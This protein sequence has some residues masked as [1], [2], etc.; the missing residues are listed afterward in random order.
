MAK[1]SK[2]GLVD[3]TLR[4]YGALTHKAL[5]AYLARGEPRRYLYDLVADYPSR[6]GKMLRPSLPRQRTYL[7]CDDRAGH[8]HRRRH[9]AAA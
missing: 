5:R 1:K 2:F 3:A 7:R 8:T 9:R 6:A 4:N